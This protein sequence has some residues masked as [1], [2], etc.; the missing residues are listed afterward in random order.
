M[1]A[2][3]LTLAPETHQD[4]QRLAWVVLE[5]D[6]VRPVGAASAACPQRQ[7]LSVK[8]VVVVCTGFAACACVSLLCGAWIAGWPD[9]WVL[10]SEGY[11]ARQQKGPVRGAQ[12]CLQAAFAEG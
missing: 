1:P 2:A 5:P 8:P 11:C 9:D 10:V 3:L 7:D 12:A 6:R 4:V